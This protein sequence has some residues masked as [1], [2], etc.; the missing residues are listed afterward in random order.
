MMLIA[1]CGRQPEAFESYT[2]FAYISIR[3]I[4]KGSIGNLLW[5]FIPVPRH[6]ILDWHYEQRSTSSEKSGTEP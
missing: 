1:N 4:S 3:S 6:H 5:R 2:Q